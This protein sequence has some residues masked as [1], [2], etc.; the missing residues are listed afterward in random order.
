MCTSDAAAA[1]DEAAEPTTL[2]P[3]THRAC[4]GHAKHVVSLVTTAAENVNRPHGL[5]ATVPRG[6]YHPGG[7][8]THESTSAA[9]TEGL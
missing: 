1:N 4:G 3:P 5:G 8:A 7:H 9:P 6:Q 2:L